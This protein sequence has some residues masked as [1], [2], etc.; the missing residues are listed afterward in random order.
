MEQIVIYKVDIGAFEDTYILE[1]QIND[2]FESKRYYFV[3]LKT[4]DIYRIKNID[5]FIE[6]CELNDININ[7]LNFSKKELNIILKLIETILLKNENNKYQNKTSTYEQY[8]YNSLD[9]SIT[10]YDYKINK[11][12]L[13][14]NKLYDNSIMYFNDYKKTNGGKY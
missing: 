6:Y 14:N 12:I 13:K 4:Y 1:Y 7:K 3:S 11:E 5:D 8:F 2:E 9:T 10:D